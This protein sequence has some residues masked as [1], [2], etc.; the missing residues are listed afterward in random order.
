MALFNSSTPLSQYAD[1]PDLLPYATTLTTRSGKA[2]GVKKALDWLLPAAGAVVGTV[3]APGIGTQLGATLGASATSAMNR[4]E[5]RKAVDLG[6]DDALKNIDGSFKST[7][8]AGSMVNLAASFVPKIPGAAAATPAMQSVNPAAGSSG[9]LGEG[10]MQ[11]TGMTDYRTMLNGFQDDLARAGQATQT[12]MTPVR[13]KDNSLAGLTLFADGGL[14]TPELL[15]IK[16]YNDNASARRARL[17]RMLNN[18]IDDGVDTMPVVSSEATQAVADG[19][20]YVQNWMDNRGYTEYANSFPTPQVMAE[21]PFKAQFG[22][23]AGGAN[24]V[25]L[26][27]STTSYLRDGMNPDLTRTAAVEE[28]TH[29]AQRVLA[30]TPEMQQSMDLLA[31]RIHTDGL[32]PDQ[33]AY[34]G[35]PEEAG[36]RLMRMREEIG[37]DPNKRFNRLGWMFKT[38]FHKPEAFKDLRQVM[39]RGDIFRSLNDTFK[40]GGKAGTDYRR[41]LADDPTED[42]LMIDKTTG[43]VFGAMRYGERIY[44]QTA[45]DT[46]DKAVESL[47]MKPTKDKFAWL[48]KFIHDETLTHKDQVAKFKDGGKP[49]KPNENIL[50]VQKELKKMGYY[51]GEADGV[52]TNNLNQAITHWNNAAR[53]TGPTGHGR[54]EIIRGDYDSVNDLK[55]HPAVDNIGAGNADPDTFDSGEIGNIVI[56]KTKRKPEQPSSP[57]TPL[58]LVTPP[59]AP[60]S[61]APTMAS[62]I[63]ET[64]DTARYNWLNGSNLLNAGRVVG[65]MIAASTPYPDDVDTSKLNMLAREAE[66]RREDGL[67]PNARRFA[68]DNLADNRSTA[69]EAL[70]RNAG[71]GGS[72]GAVLAGIGQIGQAEV[73]GDVALGQAD[74]QQRITNRMDYRGLLGA[75]MD[76]ANQRFQRQFDAVQATRQAGLNLIPKAMQGITDDHQYWKQFED[77]DSVY[78]KYMTS[79]TDLANQQAKIAKII[80]ESN[81]QQILKTPLVDTPTPVVGIAPSTTAGILTRPV[82]AAATTPTVTDYRQMFHVLP[83]AIASPI[84]PYRRNG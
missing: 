79:Q 42:L 4:N 43:K 24:V 58:A 46:I 57:L 33:A 67:S 11:A 9:V 80:Y 20:S 69:Y 34:L 27:G 30:N 12:T 1:I 10:A 37:Q 78:K 55:L 23:T 28:T 84:I 47:R 17:G 56:E 6:A 75:Q 31:S 5:R 66:G 54:I 2:T 83:P 63:P 18:R 82:T 59:P 65:G 41:Y 72:S 52:F 36:A 62:P 21:A 49:E 44:D 48:G 15:A 19:T 26:D 29:A 25:N 45:T 8:A 40:E 14:A 50:F 38:L 3:L 32:R 77:P 70:R 51:T 73:A 76:I 60:V 35:K 61:V 74:E 81:A 68:I 53:L 39:S 64:K 71:G 7:L 22:F 13:Q 16:P